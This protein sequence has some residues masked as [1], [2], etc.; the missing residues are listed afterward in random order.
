MISKLPS[1]PVIRAVAQLWIV[2]RHSHAMTYKVLA[3]VTGAVGSLLIIYGIIAQ[4]S[5]GMTL[6]AFGLTTLMPAPA[7][8]LLC[9]YRV[10]HGKR[11]SYGT[12]VAGGFGA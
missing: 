12:A 9:R 2:R 5:E 6:F 4:G 10:T 11:I 7:T 8:T 1:A 3:I